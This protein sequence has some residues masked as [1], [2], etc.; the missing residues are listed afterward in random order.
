MR[1]FLFGFFAIV[2][3][4]NSFAQA[5]VWDEIAQEAEESETITLFHILSCAIFCAIIWVGIQ[6][7]K[8]LISKDK[9]NLCNCLPCFNDT[10]TMFYSHLLR[11]QKRCHGI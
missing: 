1:K 9:E 6:A 7:Y 10:F 11:P 2:I 5:W 8:Y 4:L 3:S